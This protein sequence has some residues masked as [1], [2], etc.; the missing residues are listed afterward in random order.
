MAPMTRSFSPDG[1]PGQNVAAYYRARAQGDVGLILSEGTVVARPAAKNDPNVP[2]FHGEAALAGWKRVIDAVHEAHGAMGPQLWHVGS[3]RR[4][5]RQPV[6]P[7]LAR[8]GLRRTDERRGDRRHHLSLRP[9]RRG[10]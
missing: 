2:F 1:V 8:Q 10:L 9:G 6:R 7:L 5:D 4:S 3:A